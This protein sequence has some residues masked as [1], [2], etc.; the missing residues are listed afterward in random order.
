MGYGE[1]AVENMYNKNPAKIYAGLASAF[2]KLVLQ[3]I[4]YWKGFFMLS[5]SG[6]MIFPICAKQ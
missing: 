5:A 2:I 6:G 3:L 4:D 1:F